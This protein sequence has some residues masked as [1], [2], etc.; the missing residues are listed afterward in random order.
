MGLRF[1][2]ACGT[3]TAVELQPGTQ[4]D[5]YILETR[6][7]EGGQ[8]AVWK[9]K[10]RLQPGRSVA[11][12]LA[13][14]GSDTA[15]LERV[16]REARHLARLKHPGLPTCYAL[17]EDLHLGYLV[18]AMELVQGPT[19]AEAASA[20]VDAQKIAV[21]RQIATIL[22]FLHENGVV[23]RDLKP[24]NVIVCHEFW[25]DPLHEGAIKLIDLG[26]S[27]SSG[28]PTP[29]TVVG[30]VIGTT[31]FLAPEILDPHYF[32]ALPG[33]PAIDV[34]AFGV[35][36]W[37]LLFGS[38]PTGLREGSPLASYALAYRQADTSS[39]WPPSSRSD[40]WVSLLRRCLAVR[41]RERLASGTDLLAALR[42]D[43]PDLSPAPG[44]TRLEPVPERVSSLPATRIE[45]APAFSPAPPRSTPLPH[46]PPPPVPSTSLPSSSAPPI[47]ATVFATP[48]AFPLADHHSAPVLPPSTVP[49]VASSRS[50][51]SALLES[52]TLVKPAKKP[53]LVRYI[54]AAFLLLIGGSLALLLTVILAILFA[55]R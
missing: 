1:G 41:P 54:L 48:V 42:G 43:A 25:K 22:A 21:L 52:N 47:A 53:S 23:H 49:W 26:I 34:F 17:F 30:H 51:P 44:V 50:Q 5:R 2:G 11:L 33:T 45:H 18:V 16:R 20:L 28:N 7:G 6:L 39:L 19:L 40:D 31:S 4:I 24:E 27:V 14:M 46:S 13:P 35:L 15:H 32:P 37:L 10:D 9:A 8:G 38:H 12:K 36:G 55:L 3:L 29:L